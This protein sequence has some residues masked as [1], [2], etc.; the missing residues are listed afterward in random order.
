MAAGT[1]VH[2]SLADIRAAREAVSDVV[3]HTPVLPSATLSDRLGV[4]V[5]VKAESLQRTGSF[6]VRGTTNKVR[7]LGDDC[8]S[9][10]V[11][12][13]AGNHAMALAHTAR[14]LGVHC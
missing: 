11:T 1:A 6:K 4:D 2:P 5:V 3:R 12:A 14:A 10:V 7:R 9:G 8:A 13:S